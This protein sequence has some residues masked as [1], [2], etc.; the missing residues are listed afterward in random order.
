MPAAS[1]SD[2]RRALLA[3]L[4]LVKSE[5]ALALVEQI[6]TADPAVAS[7]AASATTQ[8]YKLLRKTPPAPK[9]VAPST[10]QPV[11]K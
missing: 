11:Q 5:K 1:D 9:P 3:A 7:E 10:P 2:D 8:I 6:A 4:G